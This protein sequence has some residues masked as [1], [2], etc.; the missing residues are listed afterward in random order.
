[1]AVGVEVGD[2]VETDAGVEEGVVALMVVT[3]ESL[4]NLNS[5]VHRNEPPVYFSCSKC[6]FKASSTEKLIHYEDNRNG[7]VSQHLRSQNRASAGRNSTGNKPPLCFSCNKCNFKASSMDKLK[8][9]EDARHG[10]GRKEIICF[11]W[12]QGTCIYGNNCRFLHKSDNN[13]QNYRVEHKTMKPCY[14]QENCNKINCTFQH[15][16]TENYC[17]GVPNRG[18][19]RVPNLNSPLEFPTLKPAWRPW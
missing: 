19:N 8:H 9:H 3:K 15:F 4:A 16:A 5:S 7:K 12:Q 17:L 11:F 13:W 6:S 2:V 18:P 1:M 10:K 14:F